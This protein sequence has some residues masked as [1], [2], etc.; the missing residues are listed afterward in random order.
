[1]T[2]HS[3]TTPLQP[4]K[5]AGVGSVTTRRR[6]CSLAG[7]FAGYLAGYFAGYFACSVLG[8]AYCMRCRMGPMRRDATL[9][10]G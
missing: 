6:A 2:A 1:M 8:G 10:R 4:S 7:Y 9:P 3:V 5:T